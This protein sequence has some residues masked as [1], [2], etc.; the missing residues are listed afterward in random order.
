MAESYKELKEQHKQQIDSVRTE[1]VSQLRD[2]MHVLEENVLLNVA[3]FLGEKQVDTILDDYLT[4]TGIVDAIKDKV[5]GT[6]LKKSLAWD[7]ESESIWL[8]LYSKIEKARESLIN[9]DKAKAKADFSEK[10]HNFRKEFE[11]DEDF[12]VPDEDCDGDDIVIDESKLELEEYDDN[13]P[14]DKALVA[15][16]EIK[17]ID[18]KTPIQYK[19]WSRLIKEPNPSVDCSG[20]MCDVM[21]RAWFAIGDQTSRSLFTKFDAKKLSSTSNWSID[22]PVFNKTEPW[23]LL[24]WDATNPSYDWKWSKIPTID[25]QW[26]KH[27]IH[28][29]AMVTE[30]LGDGRLRVFESNGKDGVIERIVDPKNELT[31]KSKS[32]LYVSHMRYDVLPRKKE[33]I[34]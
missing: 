8:S 28:H 31:S 30:K 15:I 29:V 13:E 32:A 5:L 6:A 3:L 21:R 7:E 26:T 11:L 10:L 23:D 12:Y 16:N 19:M 20:L 33:A 17:E 14:R 25:V 1:V 9:L 18:K 27:R 24:Y 34:V 4:R 2:E 22:A